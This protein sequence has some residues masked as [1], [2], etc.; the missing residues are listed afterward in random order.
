MIDLL[1]TYKVTPFSLIMGF[2]GFTMRQRYYGRAWTGYDVTQHVSDIKQEDPMVYITKTGIV[3][4]LNRNCAY[5]NPSVETVSVSDVDNRRNQSGGK[6]H[7]CEICDGDRTKGQVYITSQ[8]SSYHSQIQCLGLKRTIY[9]IPLS[10]VQG[11]GAC[12]KCG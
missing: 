6:Y 7:S 4:H 9:T 2:K 8:G 12:S 5:L 3:Y 10:E 1:V 11:R